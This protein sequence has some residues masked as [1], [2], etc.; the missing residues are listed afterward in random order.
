MVPAQVWGACSLLGN[1][2]QAA[3]SSSSHMPCLTADSFRVW[4]WCPSGGA[5][6]PHVCRDNHSRMLSRL[7]IVPA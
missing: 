4:L 2:M 6:H 5:V 3:H 7:E 1:W